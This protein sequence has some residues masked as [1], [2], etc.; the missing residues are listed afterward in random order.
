LGWNGEIRVVEEERFA[1]GVEVPITLSGT[2][3]T[4]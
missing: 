2:E 1:D 4:R 3:D